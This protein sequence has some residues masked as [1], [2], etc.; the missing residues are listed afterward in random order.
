MITT[1]DIKTAYLAAFRDDQFFM[2]GCPAWTGVNTFLRWRIDFHEVLDSLPDW[3]PFSQ[4]WAA[5]CDL[6]YAMTALREAKKLVARNPSTGGG[7]SFDHH[8]AAADHSLADAKAA[9]EK[10]CVDLRTCLTLGLVV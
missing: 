8:V 4:L 9:F 1:S 10:I 5:F 2:K 3:H 6:D 7:L